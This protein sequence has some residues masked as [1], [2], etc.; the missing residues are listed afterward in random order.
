MAK[1][2]IVVPV[3]N[4]E[5]CLDNCI[6]SVV[7][8]SYL[9]FELVLVDDGSIDNS[10]KVCD[11][12]AKK[13][14]RIKVVH[15]E[16]GGVSSARNEGIR[17]AQGEYLLFLDA[18]D[19]V[20]EKLLERCLEY[21]DLYDVFNYQAV[22]VLSLA[23]K[24]DLPETETKIISF[25]SDKDRAIYFKESMLNKQFN[26]VCWRSCYRR[27]F[28]EENNLFFDTRYNMAEDIVFNIAL[29]QNI[30]KVVEV[31][32]LGVYHYRNN[33][34]VCN[35][36]MGQGKINYMNILSYNLYNELKFK[37]EILNVFPYIHL[38]FIQIGQRFLNMD[39]EIDFLIKAHEIN[40]YK[41]FCK[42]NLKKALKA[43]VRVIYK[44]DDYKILKTKKALL[45]YIVSNNKL[46]LKINIAWINFSVPF[47]KIFAKIKR[48]LKGVFCKK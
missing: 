19:F 23:E 10:S 17:Q 3:Y 21:C 33:D 11:D 38:Y 31:S 32:F 28:L 5:N 40:N 24:V 16:N 29:V 13:D 44:Y 30:D 12:W 47:V 4:C 2:S 45:L 37:K 41:E 34:S 27:E 1:F 9:D 25:N 43:K 35:T 39:Y 22:S 36:L 14:N 46:K 48:R 6:Q 20:H 18:D 15:K 8:Q 42:Q 7:S 26:T